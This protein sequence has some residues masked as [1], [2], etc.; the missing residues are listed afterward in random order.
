MSRALIPLLGK[1][2]GL[3]TVVERLGNNE[4]GQPRWLCVCDCGNK[5]VRLGSNIRPDKRNQ[6]R[7]CGCLSGTANLSH[8]HAN[9]PIYRTWSG[10]IQ[11]CTN[12][13]RGDFH[14]YGGRGIRICSRWFVFEH[15]L[16][17]M[18]ERP[19]GLTLDR[20]NNDG[21][22]EPSNC[23]WA[24]HVEQMNNTSKHLQEKAA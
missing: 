20:I 12:P 17:D 14:R 11:R 13:A 15:F 19:E 1:R 4:L 9:T 16:A 21:N 24:T 6:F 10:M 22:Y 3:L 8:G 23:R 18:G 5:I 7:N 2:F